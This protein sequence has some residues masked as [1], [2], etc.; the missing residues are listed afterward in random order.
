MAGGPPFETHAAPR[1]LV[2]SAPLSARLLQPCQ[3]LSFHWDHTKWPFN[4]QHRGCGLLVDLSREMQDN[5]RNQNVLQEASDC[6]VS[7]K[8][9][10]NFGR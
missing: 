6:P 10:L 3:I 1:W 8:Y 2:P 4:Q 7:L 5:K 9:D